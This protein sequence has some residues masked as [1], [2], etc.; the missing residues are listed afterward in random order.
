MDATSKVKERL[1]SFLWEA[2]VTGDYLLRRYLEKHLSV[3]M[4]LVKGEHQN[5][6]NHPSIIHFSMN[7]A[8]TQYVRDLLMRCAAENGLIPVGLAEYAF[9]TKFPYLDDLSACEMDRYQY[10]F[11]PT[12]YLYSVFGGMIEGISDFEKYCVLLMVRDPRD[13]LVSEYYSY[14]FS[15]SEPSRRGNK[16]DKFMQMR[17]KARQVTIDEYAESEC[18]RVHATYQRYIDLLLDRYSHVY[19]TKYEEMA[20]DFQAWLKNLLAYCQLEISDELLASLQKEA[21][22]L[23]PKQEDIHQH[24]RKGMPGDYKVKLSPETV[25]SLDSKFFPILRRFGYVSP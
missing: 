5:E 7:K 18:G 25:N 12:G 20:T 21:Q 9:H 17:R 16:Y 14:G 1:K 15:H 8:A 6:N 3:E 13:V 4:K 22:H 10:L 23:R 11:K 2:P 24:V 19:V